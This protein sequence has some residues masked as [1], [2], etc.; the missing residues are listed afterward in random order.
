MS[1]PNVARWLSALAGVAAGAAVLFI[2][3]S[4]LEKS[5]Q[6]RSDSSSLDARSSNQILQLPTAN[7]AL[8]EEGGEERFFVGTVGRP[9]T[10]GTFGCV[11]SEGWQIHEG[12]DIRALQRDQLGEPTDPVMATAEGQVAYVNPKPSLSN[13][14]KYVVLR[15]A[16]DDLEIYSTYA[17][18]SEIRSDLKPGQIVKA[19][20]TIGIM[21]RTAN[22]RQGISKDRAHVHFELNLLINDRFAA[23]YKRTFPG[24]RNDHGAWNGQNLVALDPRL[25]LLGQ[26]RLG[27][28]FNLL[29][30]LR[31]QTELCRVLVTA[32]NFP[33]LRRYGA[34]IRPNP[35]A[36]K[37]GVAGFEIALNFNAV[38]FELIPRA[39]SEIKSKAKFQ[40]LSVNEAEYR[41]NPCRRLVTQRGS[42]WELT[43]Q[44]QRALALLT[45]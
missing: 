27:A 40:L 3:Q 42:H 29:H 44:G 26:Q 18:L 35:L 36:E 7:R 31:N 19:G 39:A 10:S 12:L 22:T 8:F 24:Q 11:R 14:G 20:E 2:W 6:S 9:W 21:G 13:F 38:P 16:I 1:L 34:L 45:Y 43:T 41:K 37:E 15:H 23:W 17:H 32:T 28:K 25:I 4:L 33:W 5:P 30:H